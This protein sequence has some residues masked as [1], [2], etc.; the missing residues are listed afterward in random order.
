VACGTD[1]AAPGGPLPVPPQP[2]PPPPPPPFAR[3]AAVP[4]QARI[5]DL[6]YDPKRDVLYLAQETGIAVY[7]LV[8]LDYETGISTDANIPTAVDLSA[9]GDSLIISLPEAQA[10]GV[11]DLASQARRVDTLVLAEFATSHANDLRVASNGHV[12]IRAIPTGSNRRF[13]LDYNLATG[14]EIRRPEV[15]ALT[16]VL[17]PIAHHETILVAFS[18]PPSLETYLYTASDNLFTVPVRSRA[19]LF[20]RPSSTPDGSLLLFGSHLYTGS[21]SFV[22]DL[23]V[24]GNAFGPTA[25]HPDAEV[26]YFTTK[27]R[28]LE[29][30][31]L[32]GRETRRILTAGEPQWMFVPPD[33]EQIVV[34]TKTTVEV[35]KP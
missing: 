28:L 24:S 8:T 32:D 19:P 20:T 23:F 26:A 30:D 12:I 11:I 7:S 29:I 13:A 27:T 9:S 22:R 34:F 31:L 17:R 10:L 3:L 21:L 6:T 18:A 15:T 33:G 5:T 1:S 16:F 35:F 4:L 2:P 25:F 14:E